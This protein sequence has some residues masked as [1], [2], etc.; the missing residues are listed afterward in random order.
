MPR[1]LS[2]RAIELANLKC[3]FAVYAGSWPEWVDLIDVP[4]W[5]QIETLRKE[6]EVV[7]S[8]SVARKLSYAR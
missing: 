7:Q 1:D 6:L 5:K 3:R 4:S 2:E 8:N